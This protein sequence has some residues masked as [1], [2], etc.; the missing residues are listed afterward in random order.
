MNGV[1][2][3]AAVAAC[4]LPLL[5]SV[6]YV[7]QNRRTGAEEPGRR[8]DRFISR[9]IQDGWQND[10]KFVTVQIGCFLFDFRPYN[11]AG[12]GKDAQYRFFS[13][14]RTLDL[15]DQRAIV[16]LYAWLV[17]N[18]IRFDFRFKWNRALPVRY[19]LGQRRR[20]A[21]L[22]SLMDGLGREALMSWDLSRDP[23][24]VK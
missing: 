19:N 8:M 18:D 23:Y 21:Y 3:P 16:K 17:Q 5:A 13:Y 7:C 14:M 9:L 2:W 6:W 1:L 11:P 12:M 15:S 20:P 10:T 22:K 24:A 4:L